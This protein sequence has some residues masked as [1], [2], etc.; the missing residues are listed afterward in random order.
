MPAVHDEDAPVFADRNAV[1]GIELTGAGIG[2][3]FRTAAPVHQEFPVLVEL[4]HA[5]AAVSVADEERTVGQ[6]GNIG[7]PVE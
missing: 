1:H 4:G 2:G 7:W 6:P 3:I 5:R